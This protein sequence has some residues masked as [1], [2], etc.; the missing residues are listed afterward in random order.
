MPRK[1]R[2]VIPGVPYHVTQRGNNRQ[3][4]FFADGD[5]FVYLRWLA[6]NCARYGLDIRAYCLMTNHIHLVA[7]PLREDSLSRAVGLTD[8][9]YAQHVNK[10]HTRT[11]HLWQSRFYSCA[12]DDKHEVAAMRY[13]EQN[14]VREGLV[15]DASTY[16]WSSAAAHLGDV[17]PSGLLDLPA[18]R[19][20]WTVDDWGKMLASG[21]PETQVKTLRR[22]TSRGW[23]LGSESFV[24]K[25]ERLLL[26][27]ARPLPAGRPKGWRK[28]L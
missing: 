27:R 8:A 24:T 3:D 18:W 23:P 28:T 21:L 13:V 7:V 6:E 11:G 1:P 17:D 25:V 2:V 19:R 5:R 14:P 16:P 9:R 15:A 4:V 10:V 20:Q 22:H 12:L 26:R